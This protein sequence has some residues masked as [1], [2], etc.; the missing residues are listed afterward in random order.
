VDLV[1]RKT[2]RSIPVEIT[3]SGNIINKKI[4]NLSHFLTVNK[5]ANFG[6][7]IYKGELKIIKVFHKPIFCLP[8]WL[9]W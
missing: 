8:W 6:L 9:W 3:N 2:G 1:L 7:I 5:Q 4:L